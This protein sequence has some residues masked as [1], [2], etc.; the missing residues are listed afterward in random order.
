[1]IVDQIVVA[2]DP[3]RAPPRDVTTSASRDDAVGHPHDVEAND[4]DPA[5][6]VVGGVTAEGAGGLPDKKLL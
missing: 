2:Y 6:A 3:P 4:E 1:M 5:A